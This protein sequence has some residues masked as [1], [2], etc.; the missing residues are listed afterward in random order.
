MVIVSQA[1]CQALI[2]FV[3]ESVTY[4]NFLFQLVCETITKVFS[5]YI[6]HDQLSGV[7]VQG[8]AVENTS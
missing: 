4:W 6:L 5:Y 8:I 1:E 7:A 3:S 2:G